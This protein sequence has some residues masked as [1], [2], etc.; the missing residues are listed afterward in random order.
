[1]PGRRHCGAQGKGGNRSGCEGATEGEG[2][3]EREREGEVQPEGCNASGHEGTTEVEGEGGR[4]REGDLGQCITQSSLQ[5][6]GQEQQTDNEG[7]AYVR[8]K[9]KGQREAAPPATAAK[10]QHTGKEQ[11]TTG[12]GQREGV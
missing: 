12:K 10:K 1:M 7:T 9:S 6:A 11:Q 8:A 4:E 5:R 2:E 3:R